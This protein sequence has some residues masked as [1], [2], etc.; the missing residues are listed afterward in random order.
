[1]WKGVINVDKKIG[2]RGWERVRRFGINSI[3]EEKTCKGDW[4]SGREGNGTG[5]PKSNIVGPLRKKTKGGSM[6][7]I[8]NPE[9]RK[10]KKERR[11]R[12]NLA[13]DKKMSR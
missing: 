4:F 10:E 2:D 5:N 9:K 12:K 11:K 8:R 1:M 7:T 3:A 13:I 6:I